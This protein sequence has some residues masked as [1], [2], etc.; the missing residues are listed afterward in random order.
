MLYKNPFEPNKIQRCDK[1]I[2]PEVFLKDYYDMTQ[3]FKQLVVD[4]VSDLRKIIGNDYCRYIQKKYG[5][6]YQNFDFASGELMLIANIHKEFF[7]NIPYIF[8]AFRGKR[9]KLANDDPDFRSI[10][11]IYKKEFGQDVIYGI[12]PLS[13]IILEIVKREK[14]G[15]E[16]V[17]SSFDKGLSLELKVLNLYT[18]L[19][20]SVSS[21]PASGDFG[22]DLIVQS[23]REKIG[24]QCKNY[25]AKVGVDAVMQAHAGAAYY[26]CSHGTVIT[27]TGFT[28]AANKMAEKL[29]VELLII[30]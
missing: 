4:N 2:L 11:R 29:D 28:D 9:I 20:Y 5:R 17:G 26:D 15:L 8:D 13:L 6:Q 1:I 25:T 16:A 21:T 22:I 23:N 18:S 10:R 3:G 7:H 14:K 24:I 27:T 19:G 30:P 12:M